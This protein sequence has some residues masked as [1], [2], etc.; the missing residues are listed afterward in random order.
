MLFVVYELLFALAFLFLARKEK[1]KN[2]FMSLCRILCIFIFISLAHS[3]DCFCPIAS[4][5]VLL[6]LSLSLSLFYSISFPCFE[7]FI[8]FSGSSFMLWF[9]V[10]FELLLNIYVFSPTTNLLTNKQNES[11]SRALPLSLDFSLSPAL[12]ILILNLSFYCCIL[13]HLSTKNLCMLFCLFADL[14]N[15]LIFLLYTYIHTYTHN[16]Q[17]YYGC[18]FTHTSTSCYSH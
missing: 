4:F 12:L 14:E 11:F 10:Q 13:L 16:S 5:S 8:V 17:Y 1:V 15:I 3:L 2:S 18:V 6:S 9:D 7:Y